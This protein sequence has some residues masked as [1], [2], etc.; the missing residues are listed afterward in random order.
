[1]DKSKELLKNTLIIAVG[2][3]CTQFISFFLL[4]VYTS[5]L[6]TEE[7]GLVDLLSTLVSFLIPLVAIQIEQASFRYL[8]EAR[9]N[10]E[11]KSRI[12]S[13][14]IMFLISTIT[15]YT[16]IFLIVSGFIHNEY[17][18]FLLFNVIIC[19]FSNFLL[20]TA[21]G[22]GKNQHYALAG[23]ISAVST[24]V[25]N[26]L[27]VVVLRLGAYGIL[28]ANFIG[29]LFCAIFLL[30][31][32]RLYKYLK[33]NKADTKVVKSLLGYSLPLVPNSL[34]W[35]IINNSDRTIITI[36]LGVA[37]N[38]IYSAANKFST[39]YISIYN[40][41]N[42]TWTESVSVHINDKEGEI[43]FIRILDKSIRIFTSI[44][45]GIISI[46]PFAFHFL[47][48][49]KFK[50]AFYQ[51]PLLMIAS[52]L[53]ALIGLISTLYIAKKMTVEVAKTSAMA[54]VINIVLNLLFIRS[55]GLYAASIS[56]IL[57]YGSMLIYRLISIDRLFQIRLDGKLM[58]AI[59][60]MYGITLGAY[61]SAQPLLQ[62]LN[63]ILIVIFCIFIN[64]RLIGSI[65]TI[66][67]YRKYIHEW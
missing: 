3:I 61:Y 30:F 4:P 60:I 18:Y 50:L 8:I 29:N 58:T 65:I 51:I 1:M 23:M 43:F 26:I 42:I 56:T 64:R 53:N 5:L 15:I 59:F 32:L 49:E 16:F 66:L 35:W 34:S 22:L 38:G 31:A 19:I 33:L 55:L 9:E 40:I 44:S 52:F 27:F 36:F 41:F 57:A 63:L 13:S 48:D 10:E 20:E 12:I 24:L 37:L 7:Y 21:R 62:I 11:Q 39:V 45:L 28:T 25:L 54:A 17:K 47:I 14:G 67:K 6:T 2:K 46:M